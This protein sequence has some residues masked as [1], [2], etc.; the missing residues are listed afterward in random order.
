MSSLQQLETERERLK[1]QL[2][3]VGDMRPGSLVGRFRKCGKASCHCAQPASESHGPSW[4]LTRAV[5]GKTVT[6]VIPTG[7][8]VEQ[9][10]AQIAEYRRFRKLVQELIELNV[11]ICDQKLENGSAGTVSKKNVTRRHTGRRRRSGG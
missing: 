7:S 5:E 11:R 8:G 4:S 6:K 1:N 3:R 10:K 9:T 2:S